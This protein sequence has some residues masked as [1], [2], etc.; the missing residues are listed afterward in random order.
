MSNLVAEPIS[1]IPSDLIS[2]VHDE[3]P[4]LLK[5]SLIGGM[6]RKVSHAMNNYLT[7]MIGYIQLAEK[8]AGVD[9]KTRKN[10]TRLLQCC[11]SAK[12]LNTTLAELFSPISREEFVEDI[13]VFMD[14]VLAFCNHIFGPNCSIVIREISPSI[15]IAAPETPLKE[16]LLYLLLHANETMNGKGEMKVSIGMEDGLLFDVLENYVPFIVIEIEANA[17][18]EENSN[19]LSH[20]CHT[21]SMKKIDNFQASASLILAKS[22]ASQWGGVVECIQ[23]E[24]NRTIDRLRLPQSPAASWHRD[25]TSPSLDALSFHTRPIRIVLLEDQ[26]LISEFLQISLEKEG[27]SLEIFH[28]GLELERYLSHTDIQ[29]IDVFI[30]DVLV[31][32]RSGLEVAR[33]IRKKN[34]HSKILFYSALSNEEDVRREFSLNDNTRFL[35]KPFKKEEL[36]MSLHEMTLK[37]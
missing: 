6:T 7:G 16:M 32:G 4:L 30:L 36:F 8:S 29:L 31:P 28:D 34:R 33:S 24:E 3:N 35:P 23:M 21:G 19:D 1:L 5:Y 14:D 15:R 13:G 27:H 2:L 25:N 10:M 17:L 22:L 26:E 9:A 37:S 12:L 11:E 18:T 20:V